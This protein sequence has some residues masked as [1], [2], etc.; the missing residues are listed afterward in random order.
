VNDGR[1]Y[2]YAR[3]SAAIATLAT[4][5]GLQLASAGAASA[6]PVSGS[7]HDSEV[8][9]AQ[10]LADKLSHQVDVAAQRHD[11]VQ[12]SLDRARKRTQALTGFI[13]QEKRS[14]RSLKAQVAGM[15]G[16]SY[17][18]SGGN[19]SPQPV[20]TGDS[21]TLL[22]NVVVVTENTGGLAQSMAQS[23]DT[24]EQLAA[25]RAQTQQQVRTLRVREHALAVKEDELQARSDAAAGRVQDLMGG[26][27]VQYALSKVGNGYVFGASGPSVFDCSGLTMAAWSQAGVSLPHSSSAQYSSG[28]HI[29]ESELQPGDLVFYYSPISHV[30][31]YIGGGKI[32]NALNPGAG[33]VIS[34]LHDMPYVGAVRPG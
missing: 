5:V 21:A 34:G 25:Q 6:A 14:T 24:M 12:A 31:M 23:A 8:A 4:V 13:R 16:E 7:D 11:K 26:P 30:G 3:P 2:N 18:A 15:A 22:S 32:V 27:A 9:A 20:L 19:A 17:D 28:R 10:A 33:V 29:S 1:K